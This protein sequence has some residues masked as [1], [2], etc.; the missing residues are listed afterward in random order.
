MC[1]CVHQHIRMCAL[2]FLVPLPSLNYSSLPCVSFYCITYLEAN[3][4][5]CVCVSV[6]SCMLWP[7]S[8][9]F[10]WLLIT[11]NHS[12]SSSCCS[13][14]LAFLS[15]G[16]QLCV[17]VGGLYVFFCVCV[18]VWCYTFWTMRLTVRFWLCASPWRGEYGWRGLVTPQDT[19][20]ATV[21]PHRLLSALP[22]WAES[23]TWTRSEVRGTGQGRRGLLGQHAFSWCFNVF[24][25]NSR[26]KQKK[27]IFLIIYLFI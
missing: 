6:C 23:G 10:L 3:R 9:W 1:V 16:S 27:L 22:R 19:I 14:P 24:G 26:E 7:D 8:L 18:C 25:S 21:A 2:A 11:G 17:C 12:V 13:F 20:S 15:C 5:V 4:S